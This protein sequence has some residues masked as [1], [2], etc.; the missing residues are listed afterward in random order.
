M[1]SEGR[2]RTYADVLSNMT[3]FRNG[4]FPVDSFIMDYDWFQCGTSEC[5]DAVCHR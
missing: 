2:Y 4:N 3:G 1:R 5:Y